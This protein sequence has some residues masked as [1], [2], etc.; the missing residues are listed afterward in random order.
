MSAPATRFA[1]LA[2]PHSESF[3]DLKHYSET[4][5]YEVQD[6]HNGQTRIFPTLTAATNFIA[7]HN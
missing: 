4:Y 2:R 6:H 5:F 7:T 3:E 1:V